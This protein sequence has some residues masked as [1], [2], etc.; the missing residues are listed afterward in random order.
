M[1]RRR[2]REVAPFGRFRVVNL[3]EITHQGGANFPVAADYLS[4]L[5][6][7]KGFFHAVSCCC[8]HRRADRDRSSR[9][10]FRLGAHRPQRDDLSLKVAANGQAL[11]TY[12]ARGKRRTRPRLGRDQRAP[13][14]DG[15]PAGRVPL[16][17]SGGW[18]TYHSA[19]LEGLPNACRPY[20]GPDAA[21]LVTGVQGARRL[22]LGVQSW[23]KM[24]PNSASPPTPEQAAWELRLSHWT[25]ELPQLDVNLDWAYRRYDHLYGGFTYRG[26]AGLRLHVDAA[27]RPAR[28]VRPEHLRRHVQLRVRRRA[29]SA[30]TA[31]SCTT[32]RGRSATA[33]TAHG[34]RARRGTASATA[35]RRSAPA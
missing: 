19:R 2:G 5:S 3:S 28:H 10:G 25:G 4:R 9:D 32:G 18:G 22:L 30:R 17:Y 35:R 21:W 23:Q 20:D 26:A 6:S 7:T 15:A 13:A 1:D 8:C 31:S 12:N 11:L 34:S 27:R 14:D 33:S 16:D 29:G 24:L